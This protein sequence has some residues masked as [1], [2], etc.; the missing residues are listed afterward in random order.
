MSDE[1]PAASESSPAPVPSPEPADD[2]LTAEELEALL[3]ARTG[4][5][6]IWQAVAIIAVLVLAAIGFGWY[7]GWF[8]AAAGSGPPPCP[9]A[10]TLEGT[11]PTSVTPIVSAWATTLG[12]TSGCY[13]IAFNASALHGGVGAL[14]NRTVQ[15]LATDVPLNATEWKALPAP[16]LTLPV[17]LDA[18]AVV[19]NVPGVGSGLHLDGGVLASVYLG[20]VTQWNDPAIA[21]LN[22]GVSLPAGV[23]IHP[24]HQTDLGG[25]TRLFSEYLA[26]QNGSWNSAT[27]AGQNPVWP[28]GSSAS[29]EPA[30]LASLASQSGAVGYVSWPAATGA[31]APMAELPDGAGGYVGPN[32][33]SVAAAA[34][35]NTSL[36]VGNASW[37]GVSLLD[38]AAPGA[39]PLSTFAY[40]ITYADLGEAY[41]PT[42]TYS[43]A[44]WLAYFFFWVSLHGANTTAALAYVPL[45]QP[46]ATSDIQILELLNYHGIHLTSDIDK[47]KDGGN[48]EPYLR[49]RGDP[50]P[51][52]GG[53]RPYIR[54][55]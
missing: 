49:P 47:D 55:T 1:T 2:D 5:K 19:Y 38:S 17:A 54:P 50:G 27:A 7:A 45:P 40:L 51:V 13:Q 14:E 18:V 35:L 52:A 25:T 53:L 32:P 3:P 15:Y 43:S 23:G 30:L 10:L 26:G 29:S 46:Q 37:A 36:P 20:A 33:G 28:V 39:Y 21:A 8:A 6:E 11:G 22:P 48:Y 9:N 4:S 16:V 34:P 42:L 41:G 24:L 44:D 12:H 31:A